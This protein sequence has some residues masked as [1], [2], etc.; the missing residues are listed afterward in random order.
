MRHSFDE[1]LPRGR[2]SP[3]AALAVESVC[4]AESDAERARIAISTRQCVHHEIAC[5]YAYKLGDTWWTNGLLSAPT[6][7]RVAPWLITAT[8][9]PTL[10]FTPSSSTQSRRSLDDDNWAKLLKRTIHG[11]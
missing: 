9:L 6:C 5:D 8:Q 2:G 4:L 3:H 1:P 11:R 7:K 10:R